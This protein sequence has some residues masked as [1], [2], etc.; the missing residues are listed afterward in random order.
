[1][2]KRSN[3]N[4]IKSLLCRGFGTSLSKLE[5]WFANQR[6]LTRS[7][8]RRVVSSCRAWNQLDR[9]VFGKE[10]GDETRHRVRTCAFVSMVNL[11][12]LSQAGWMLVKHSVDTHRV[13]LG[14]LVRLCL[15]V[16]IKVRKP[17]SWLFRERQAN[18]QST[19]EQLA[20]DG[21]Y[22]LNLPVHRNSAEIEN[23]SGATHDV[24]GDPNVTK[25]V[26]KYPE[27]L[28]IVGHSKDHHQTRHE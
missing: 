9:L 23:R 21:R 8:D 16:E 14:W 28:Q 26:T 17:A 4:I 2:Q 12:E 6:D 25:L 7:N 18:E 22:Q 3:I 5:I 1:M 13:Y 24:K 15:P 11:L 27:S 10:R 20:I 19:D